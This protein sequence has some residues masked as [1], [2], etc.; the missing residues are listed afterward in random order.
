MWGW[1]QTTV[2][3]GGF[4]NNF[5]GIPVN[6]HMGIGVPITFMSGVRG[7][8]N[9]SWELMKSFNH[10][11]PSSP[12]YTATRILEQQNGRTKNTSYLQMCGRRVNIEDVNEAKLSV[13]LVSEFTM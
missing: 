10:K 13:V 2:Y 11:P 5:P 4:I 3:G 7:T 8:N 1:G 9:F 12:V 6:V